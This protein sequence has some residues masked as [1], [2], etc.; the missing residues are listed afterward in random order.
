[1]VCG[2]MA[3][4]ERDRLVTIM[5]VRTFSKSLTLLLRELMQQAGLADA[6][7]TNDDVLKDI[8]VVIRALRHGGH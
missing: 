4:T 8:V 6:H 1:M 2:Q 5:L 3:M 7:V